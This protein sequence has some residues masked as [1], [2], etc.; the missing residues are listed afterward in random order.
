M[1]TCACLYV[2][3]LPAVAFFLMEYQVTV[4]EGEAINY[5]AP[6]MREAARTLD[7][8]FLYS[9]RSQTCDVLSRGWLGVCNGPGIHPPNGKP[10]MS[11]WIPGAHITKYLNPD[12]SRQQKVGLETRNPRWRCRQAY[13]LSKTLEDSL[14]IS[15]LWKMA[16]ILV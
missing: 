10:E 16:E 12:A 7:S 1:H 9:N 3:Y 5:Q 4:A 2:N 15:S 14:P 13:A 6:C 8:Q 11:C